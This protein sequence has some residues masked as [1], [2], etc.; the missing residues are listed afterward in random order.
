MTSSSR[1]LTR[2][3][4]RTAR[5]CFA[6]RRIGRPD[7]SG[8][9]EA[10]AHADRHPP[11]YTARM[12]EVL[13]IAAIAALVG[14]QARANILCALLDGRSLAASEL[15]YAAHVTPQTASGHL[16]KLAAARL[17]VSVQQG[18]HR[19]FHL[20]GTHIAAMI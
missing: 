7:A 9:A 17:I 5:R 19:Y 16:G 2:R 13:D 3:W 14:D 4:A 15:A 6:P 1:V 10:S 12:S 18:R 20:A 11:R 8:A